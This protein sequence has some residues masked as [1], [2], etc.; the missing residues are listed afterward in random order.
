MQLK[1]VTLN[2]LIDLESWE[3]RCPLIINCIKNLQPDLIALQEVALFPNNAKEIA[4]NLFGYNVYTVQNSGMKEGEEGLAILSKPVV[5]DQ[6]VLDLEYQNRKAQIITFNLEDKIF[7][8]VN[9][10]LFWDDGPAPERLHQVKKII[11]H[12]NTL[13]SCDHCII[14]GDFNTTPETPSIQAIKHQFYSAYE[15][16]K[17][18]EPEATFPTPLKRSRDYIF[19][20]ETGELKLI[21]LDSK[22]KPIL[23][24]IDYIFV[25]RSFKILNSFITFNEPDINDPNIFPS[26]HFGLY[27][28]LEV[29]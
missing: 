9:T 25:S 17:G 21:L 19:E 13:P 5:K 20:K 27:A 16:Y 23:K 10:H 4:S 2:L 14:C 28:D 22:E 26:D 15:T 7:H 6:V 1:I 8:L 29:C 24:T 11:K 18:S 3:K 12:L